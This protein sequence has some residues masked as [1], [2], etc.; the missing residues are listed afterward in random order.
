MM[1]KLATTIPLTGPSLFS[2]DGSIHQEYVK[3]RLTE[4]DGGSKPL[5]EDRDYDLLN[6]ESKQVK[7]AMRAATVKKYKGT[8]DEAKW[9]TVKDQA[10]RDGLTQR[11][12]NDA[13][14]RRIV[15]A[16]R[17]QGK[18]LLFYTPGAATNMGGIRRDDGRIE[19]G[20]KVWRNFLGRSRLLKGPGLHTIHTH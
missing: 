19:G 9:A 3:Q 1:Y 2:R 4:T 10:L 16:A 15:E 13:R 12:E 5:P 20:N 14:L 7:D 8:F 17:N 11:W 6:D 18:I